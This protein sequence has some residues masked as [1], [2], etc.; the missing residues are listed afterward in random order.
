MRSSYLPAASSAGRRPGTRSEPGTIDVGKLDEFEHSPDLAAPVMVN[1]KLRR[2][3]DVE[4]A[5]LEQRPLRRNPVCAL[6]GLAVVDPAEFDQ[7]DQAH[8]ACRR[9][10]RSMRS[11]MSLHNPGRRS[12]NTTSPSASTKNHIGMLSLK[13]TFAEPASHTVPR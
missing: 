12:R 9:L 6:Q 2:G 13:M 11:T 3:Q 10:R 8:D 5:A 7:P 4:R 1:E